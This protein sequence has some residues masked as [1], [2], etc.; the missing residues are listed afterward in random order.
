MVTVWKEEAEQG[1]VQELGYLSVLQQREPSL[2]FRHDLD[3]FKAQGL[4]FTR[5]ILRANLSPCL[6]LSE[7]HPERPAASRRPL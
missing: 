7:H 6:L 5:V 2:T 4:L 1:E 3:T